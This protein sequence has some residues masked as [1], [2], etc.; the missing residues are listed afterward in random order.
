MPA[1]CD[2]EGAGDMKSFRDLCEALP[3]YGERTLRRHLANWGIHAPK[4]RKKISLDDETFQAIINSYKCPLNS[5]NLASAVNSGTS[6][7]QSL[8]A[9]L[10]LLRAQRTKRLLKSV[11]WKL[12]IKSGLQQMS[13]Y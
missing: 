8:G 6:V 4:G 12:N 3:H 13:G 5:L 10:K 7:E 2:N 1:L 9:G 11:N